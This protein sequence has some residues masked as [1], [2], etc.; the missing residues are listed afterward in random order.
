MPYVLRCPTLHRCVYVDTVSLP[1]PVIHGGYSASENFPPHLVRYL[2]RESLPRI[3]L[4]YAVVE[5]F[6]NAASI[7]AADTMSVPL[8]A[9]IAW[10]TQSLTLLAAAG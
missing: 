5:G 9:E 2:V 1:S 4:N 7:R 10:K 8:I 6:F 3:A